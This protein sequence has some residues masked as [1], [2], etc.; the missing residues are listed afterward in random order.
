MNIKVI[1]ENGN[2]YTEEV[3]SMPQTGDRLRT[4]TIVD[5]MG[6]GPPGELV[7]VVRT[8]KDAV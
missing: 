5:V 6:F 2:T 3:D 8:M 7:I 1:P 4:E